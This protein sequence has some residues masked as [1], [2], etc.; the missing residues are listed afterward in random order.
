[1][2]IYKFYIAKTKK[3][4]K[5]EYGTRKDILKTTTKSTI[6]FITILYIQGLG[7]VI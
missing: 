2:S 5:I 7:F 6:L 3:I 1:M 4:N